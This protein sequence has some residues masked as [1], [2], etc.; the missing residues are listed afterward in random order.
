MR[1]KDRVGTVLRDE[2]RV[3][4]VLRDEDRVWDRVKSEG[5]QAWCWLD[6][7]QQ[8]RHVFGCDVDKIL[9]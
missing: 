2:G 6:L 5:G 3:G 1:D 4:T 9:T 8:L 7:S